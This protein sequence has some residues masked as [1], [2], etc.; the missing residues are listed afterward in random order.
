M[1]ASVKGYH[2]DDAIVHDCR[3]GLTNDLTG[4]PANTLLLS[5][6]VSSSKTA[7]PSLTKL[8]P[9]TNLSSSTRFLTIGTALPIIL[10]FTTVLG[11]II[12]NLLTVMVAKQSCW[13]VTL[14][15]YVVI[16]NQLAPIM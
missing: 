2:L 9:R 12:A 3:R 16:E 14:N 13:S 4:L 1:Y 6:F 15:N 5:M 8:L 10:A 11:S 7:V